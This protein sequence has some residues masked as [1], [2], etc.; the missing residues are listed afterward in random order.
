[1]PTPTSG[2]SAASGATWRSA[3]ARSRRFSTQYLTTVQPMHLQFVEPSKRYADVIVPRGGHNTVAIEM[4][5]AKIARRVARAARVTATATALGDRRAHPRRRRRAGHRRARRVS[6]R[7]GRLSR[8]HRRHRARRARAGAPR[9]ARR[10]SCSTSCCPA[11]SGYDV[12]E[13]LRAE[14]GDARRRR[15]DAHRAPRGAGP[16]PRPVARRRRLPHE[17][18]Q[19]AGAGAA[20]R[21]DPPPR[22]RGGASAGRQCSRSA[23]CAI[24]RAAHRVRVDG[25]PSR[26]HAHRVQAAAHARRAARPRAGA[27]PPA[28]DGVGRRAGHPDA[29][30]GHARPAAAHQA[31]RRRRPDRD[32]ARLRLPADAPP[33]AAAP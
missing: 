28:R 30:G 31:R 13:Q 29:H 21:G 14:R 16:H 11:L 24:D 32:G 19:P 3:A 10:S 4:I 15:A 12:L 18:V 33:S 8:V 22:R 23:R 1:M 7:E 6:P 17:A 5:V 25:D 9:S 27:R 26:A 2:S 20:R